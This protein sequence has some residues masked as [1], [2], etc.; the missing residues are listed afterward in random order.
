MEYYASVKA[1]T[2]NI[3]PKYLNNILWKERRKSQ[4][5]IYH[6]ARTC[7]VS[8]SISLLLT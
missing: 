4:K 3:N 7:V 1:K 6:V 2:T 5:N 8:H